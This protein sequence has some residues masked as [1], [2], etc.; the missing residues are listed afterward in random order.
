MNI[1][2]YSRD[3]LYEL[4]MYRALL[5]DAERRQSP[6]ALLAGLRREI[7]W[8]KAKAEAATRGAGDRK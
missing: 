3:P 2:Y 6:P 4:E 7:E 1:G 8:W 5:A